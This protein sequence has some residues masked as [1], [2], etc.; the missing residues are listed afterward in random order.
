MRSTTNFVV[1][2][3]TSVQPARPLRPTAHPVVTAAAI[4][5]AEAI[6]DHVVTVNSH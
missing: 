4:V 6:V 3:A 5:A 2:S 1:S